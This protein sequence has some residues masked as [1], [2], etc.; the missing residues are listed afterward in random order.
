MIRVI[1]KRQVIQEEKISELIRDLRAAAMPHPGYMGGETMVST[2]DKHV[3]YRDG[4][5]AQSY[6]LGRMANIGTTI[7]NNKKDQTDSGCTTGYRDL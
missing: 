6:R 3:I 7:R 1:I 5:L 4:H 2:E